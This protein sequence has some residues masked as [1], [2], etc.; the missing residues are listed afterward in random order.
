MLTAQSLYLPLGT[1]LALVALFI[2][3]DRKHPTRFSS[4]S[5]WACYASIF[6]FGDKLPEA[7]VGGMVLLM[8]ALAGTNRLK[9]KPESEPSRRWAGTGSL[10]TPALTLPVVTLLG[11]VAVSQWPWLQQ[12]VDPQHA[13]LVC[14]GVACVVGWLFALQRTKDTPL[15]SVREAQRLLEAMGYAVIL[16]QL[17]ACLGLFF[18]QTG[19][20]QLIG[21]SAALLPGLNQPFI[22]VAL[23]CLGM[24]LMTIVMGNAFAAF[25][26]MTAG[27]GIP[28]LISVHQANPAVVAAIGMFS[29]Y[30]GTLMTPMAANFNLVPVALLQ[31]DDPHAVIKAQLPTALPLL[32]VNIVLMSYLAFL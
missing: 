4:G 8:A 2:L 32:L 19:V 5:F 9:A 20:S 13:T 30:C 3:T 26:V 23:Y 18:N 12:W 21:Q 7:L 27:I 16:P 6:L 1:I 11:V 10:L 29:G 25:P 17:L 24:A 15:Q 28:L 14:L 31:L 22:A